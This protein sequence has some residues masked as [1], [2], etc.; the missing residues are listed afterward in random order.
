M[1]AG[2]SHK[3]FP[4][5]LENL[6]EMI[7]FIK[8]NAEVIGFHPE[9]IAK[10]EV[11]SEE[12]LVN[13]ISYAYP[14]GEGDL[15]IECQDLGEATLEIKFRDQ[16]VEYDPTIHRGFVKKGDRIGGYGILLIFKLMDKV[17]YQRDGD[18]NVLTIVK[19]V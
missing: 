12:V 17:E 1:T 10:L 2:K 6:Y 15:M 11:A 9:D 8:H 3:T 4:A 14:K 5:T 16:G 7:A 18:M 19:K 13:I